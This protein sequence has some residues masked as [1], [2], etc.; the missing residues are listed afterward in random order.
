MAS[1]ERSYVVRPEQKLNYKLAY[2]KDPSRFYEDAINKNI[3]KHKLQK[4]KLFSDKS[5]TDSPD[6]KSSRRSQ[7]SNDYEVFTIT[8]KT[9]K[10][11]HCKIEEKIKG[12]IE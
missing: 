4:Q 1:P 12:K 7:M 11:P 2:K 8:S 10:R 5:C 9:T 3:T 6:K